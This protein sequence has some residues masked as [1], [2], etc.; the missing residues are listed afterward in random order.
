M[1]I[2]LVGLGYA[3]HVLL[4]ILQKR[5][6][7]EIAA[8]CGTDREKTERVA[9]QHRI[10]GAY[11]DWRKMFSEQRPDLLVV[12]VPPIVQGEILSDI[13]A[14]GIPCF[15]EKPL[16]ADWPTASQIV[17]AAGQNADRS[18][19]DFIFPESAVWKRAREV[20][21]EGRLGSIR[22]ASINWHVQT[23]SSRAGNHPWKLDR[24]KGGG[25]LNN[26]VSHVLYYTE[27][28]LG[29]IVSAACLLDELDAGRDIRATMR[30]EVACGAKVSV[31]VS[32]DSPCGSGH[33]VEVYGDKGAVCLYNPSRDYIKGF[34]GFRSGEDGSEES[35]GQMKDAQD[36]ADGRKIASGMIIGR[37]IDCIRQGRGMTP[38]IRDGL[39]VQYLL[40]CL[41][42]SHQ[43][44]VPIKCTAGGEGH[45]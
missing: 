38:N 5:A 17:K 4:P 16:A 21:R 14:L 43:G 11:T 2:G 31:Q 35:L 19:V 7:C 40:D 18:A 25:V 41:A 8:L 22:H 3:R 32:Q 27:W 28:L 37:W 30:L 45:I 39:R 24:N 26:F 1:R 13:A 10:P 12:A 15:C 36:E 44:I 20:I 6:D 29:E 42:R 33:R 23:C 9:N 34:S